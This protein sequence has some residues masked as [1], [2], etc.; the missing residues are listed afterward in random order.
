MTRLSEDCELDEIIGFELGCS[1]DG[2]DLFKVSCQNGCC[3]DVLLYASAVYSS[4]RDVELL[5]Q[6]QTA[7]KRRISAGLGFQQGA[8]SSAERS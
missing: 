3:E 6:L 7:I 5:A 4:P 1:E 2:E 8:S